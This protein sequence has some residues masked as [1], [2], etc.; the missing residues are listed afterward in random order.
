MNRET[1]KRAFRAVRLLIQS[2][3]EIVCM[4]YRHYLELSE[5]S[6]S[7]ALCCYQDRQSVYVAPLQSRL[8]RFKV[9]K[10]MKATGFHAG[11]RFRPAN[12]I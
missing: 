11:E 9:F 10:K 7:D 2:D 1:F 4:T 6:N 5:Q 12:F 3:N 8:N